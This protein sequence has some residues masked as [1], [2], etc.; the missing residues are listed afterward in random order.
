MRLNKYLVLVCLFGLIGTIAHGQETWSLEKCIDYAIDNSIGVKR[1]IIGVE[2]AAVDLKRTKFSRLPNLN[3]GNTTGLNFGRFVDPTTNTFIQNN[4][5]SNSWGLSSNATLFNANRINNQVKRANI[6]LQTASYSAKEIS[7]NIAL[8][9][10]NA[11]L[12]ILLAEE[13]LENAN[14]GLELSEAELDRTQKLIEAGSLP[15]MMSWTLKL[16]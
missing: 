12:N 8:N 9:I 1:A 6:D 7:N 14:K 10:A 16:K 13:Q 2:Q 11:Y 4:I 3:I 15:K 5:I